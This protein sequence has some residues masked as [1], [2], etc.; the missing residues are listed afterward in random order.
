MGFYSQWKQVES[1]VK[2][3]PY[4]HKSFK[5]FLEAQQAF[6]QF[7]E[8]KGVT[9]SSYNH[10]NDNIQLRPKY[11]ED[12]NPRARPRLPAQLFRPPNPN[13]RLRMISFKDMIQSSV[14]TDNLPNRFKTIGKIPKSQEEPLFSGITLQNFLQCEEEAKTVGDSDPNKTYFG[15]IEKQFE[16]FIFCEGSERTIIQTAFHCG[17][18][19]MI[20]LGEKME[21]IKLIDDKLLNALKDFKKYVI[22]DQELHMVLKINSTIPLWNSEG[23]LIKGYHH[24]QIKTLPQITLNKPVTTKIECVSEQT[25]DEWRSLSYQRLLTGLRAFNNESKIKV[26]FSSSTILVTSKT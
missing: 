18:I 24:I 21:E 10:L 12:S 16:Q 26:N 1:L 2:N 13:Q 14:E 23:L 11:Y 19:K 15:T 22:K 7:Y 8:A 9:P 3:K 4:K 6:N 17:L 5:T 25:L 20:L